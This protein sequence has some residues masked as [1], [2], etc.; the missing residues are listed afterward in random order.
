MQHHH[1][2]AAALQQANAN[3]TDAFMAFSRQMIIDEHLVTGR[4]NPSDA[5]IGRIS[6][7]RWVE[8]CSTTPARNSS[9]RSPNDIQA[10]T[11]GPLLVFIWLI[12][13][14]YYWNMLGFL[15]LGDLKRHPEKRGKGRAITGMPSRCRWM[16]LAICCA[17]A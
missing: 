10:F 3:N 1:L 5:Q 6:R 17:D 7:E 9:R 15:A 13:N 14:M 11:L 16:S 4:Q 12:V 8:I 2:I